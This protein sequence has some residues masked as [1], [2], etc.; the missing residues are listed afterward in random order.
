MHQVKVERS[1]AASGRTI[2]PPAGPIPQID[3]DL[4]TRVACARE[5][6]VRAE[7]VVASMHVELRGADRSR[8]EYGHLLSRLHTF[9]RCRFNRQLELDALLRE[10]RAQVLPQVT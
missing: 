5:K 6:L 3:S 8:P 2:E 4:R 10:R 9:E 1:H 7:Q